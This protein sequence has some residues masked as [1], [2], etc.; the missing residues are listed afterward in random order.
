M[1]LEEKVKKSFFFFESGFVGND[2]CIF[3]F[4]C[5]I[6]TTQIDFLKKKYIY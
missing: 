2:K 4:N 5:I 6:I 3:N 1:R